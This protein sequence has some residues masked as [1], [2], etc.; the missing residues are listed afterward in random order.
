LKS[1][2]LALAQAIDLAERDPDPSVHRRLMKGLEEI[3][4]FTHEVLIECAWNA[5]LGRDAMTTLMAST[6]A[7]RSGALCGRPAMSP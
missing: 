3:Q 5:G 6:H 4:D 7:S 2:D 1:E